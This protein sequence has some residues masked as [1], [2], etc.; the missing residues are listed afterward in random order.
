LVLRAKSQ[1][2][3]VE[4]EVRSSEATVTEEESGQRELEFGE[5]ET[6]VIGPM[7]CEMVALFP[8]V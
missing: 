7:G 1:E 3:I 4:L 5:L 2:A 6:L 8:S